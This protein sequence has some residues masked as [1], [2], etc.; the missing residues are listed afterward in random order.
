MRRRRLDGL[1]GETDGKVAVLWVPKPSRCDDWDLVNGRTSP[2]G[3]LLGDGLEKSCVIVFGFRLGEFRG[4]M[5]NGEHVFRTQYGEP[6]VS[7]TP[8]QDI[9]STVWLRV[10]CLG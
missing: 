5:E 6:G 2:S 9:M 7:K 8:L 1:A 3:L 4:K 10:I